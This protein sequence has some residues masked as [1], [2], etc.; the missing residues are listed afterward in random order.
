MFQLEDRVFMCID[1]SYGSARAVKEGNA[2]QEGV[3]WIQIELI[4]HYL[5][6]RGRCFSHPGN[7]FNVRSSKPQP[8]DNT[9]RSPC[10]LIPKHRQ[11]SRYFF[12]ICMSVGFGFSVGDFIAAIEL[13]GTVI[14]AL[15]SSGSAAT[16]YRALVSQLLSL[17]TALLQV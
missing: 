6:F 4:I 17:E 1:E 15:R 8:R 12:D 9:S 14:D 10:I 2:Y 3:L 7:Q 5:L 16:E 11:D 13:V